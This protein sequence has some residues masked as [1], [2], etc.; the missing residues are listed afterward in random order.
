MIKGYNK[1]DTYEEKIRKICV[2]K[3]ITLKKFRRG[4]AGAKSDIEFVHK[5]KTYILEVK[6]DTKADYGQK[7]FRWNNNTWKWSLNDKVTQ[8]Y[9]KLGVLDLIQNKKITPRLFTIIREKLTQEDKTF[10]QKS[11]EQS[12]D[13]D[14]EK[15]FSYYSQKNCHYIQ[16]GGYGFYYLDK[17]IL[18]LQV[19]QF[20]GKLRLRFRAKTIHS[21]PLWNYGYYAVLKVNKPPTRSSFD[22]EELNGRKFPPI[23]P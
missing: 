6:V 23:T 10:D 17:D 22:I 7:T 9:T 5:G 3:G 2:K 8:M 1:G 20:D 15:L 19:P 13:I 11:F 18:N 4:G 14:T 12:I 21:V 16:I